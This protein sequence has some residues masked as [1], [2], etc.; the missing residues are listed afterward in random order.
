M[1]VP[2]TMVFIRIT[3]ITCLV[4]PDDT[5]GFEVVDSSPHSTKD[6]AITEFSPTVSWV[7]KMSP[8]GC[9]LYKRDTMAVMAAPQ[10]PQAGAGR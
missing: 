4:Q 3:L 8:T 9:R 7:G 1:M 6:N 2:K 10:A 5:Y